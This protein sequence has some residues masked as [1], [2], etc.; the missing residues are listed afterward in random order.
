MQRIDDISWL[1][2]GLSESKKFTLLD[3]GRLDRVITEMGDPANQYPTLCV[4][5]GGRSK[6]ACLRRLYPNNNIKRHASTAEIKLRYD[7]DS[8]NTTRPV[9]FTD[10]DLKCMP[11]AYPSTN[12]R[13]KLERSISWDTSSAEKALYIIW[14]R[15]VFL[16]ADVICVFANDFGDL[17]DVAGFLLECLSLQAP[18]SLPSAVQ[19]RVIIVLEA[20]LDGEQED[21]QNVEHFYCKLHKEGPNLREYFSAVHL[22]RLESSHLSE[23][24]RYERLR[25]LIM[26][27]LDDM[28][29]VREDHRAL[30][31]ATHLGALFR[32]AFQ[33]TAE[34]ICRP[35]DFVK[36]TR[37][38]DEVPSTLSRSLAHYL[39]IGAKAGLRYEE[40]ATS[41]SSALLMDHYIPGMLGKTIEELVGVV[42]CRLV[43]QF[44]LLDRTGQSSLEFRREQ[45]RASSGRIC[46]IRSNKICLVCLFRVAQ[47][48]LDCGH[49]L[50]DLCAQLFG[51]PAPDIEYNFTIDACL[52]CLYQRPL[53]IDVLPPTMNPTVLAIDGGGVRGVIPLEFLILVQESL[54]CCPLQDLIDL[55]VGTSS[56]MCRSLSILGLFNM[57]WGVKKCADVF[58]RMARRIFH[59][60]RS[61]TLARASQAM[62]GSHSFLGTVH[63]WL[64]WL[65]YDSCYDGRVFDLA[66]KEVY[67]INNR[68]FDSLLLEA[69][70][71]RYSKTKVGVVATS[72]ARETRSFV[73]GNFN[74]TETAAED[75]GKCRASKLVELVFPSD[76]DRDWSRLTARS[77]FP[78]ADIRGIG[79][80]Q[81][82]GLRDNLAADIA[83][84]LCRQIWPS[85]K[86]PARLLSMGTGVTARGSDR[87]PHFRHVFQDGFLRRGFD[88]WMSSMDTE[89]KWLEMIG[90]LEDIYKEDYLR[91][92]IPLRDMPSAIDTVEVMEEYRNLV[93]ISPGSARMAREAATA[94]L[95]SRFYFV[96]ETLPEDT[97]TPFWC[98]GTIRCK[99]RAKQVVD[100]LGHLHPQGL[101]Y[102][103]D[104]E[105]IGPLKG[106]SELCSACGRYCRP[107]SF[108]VAHPDKVVNIYLK[109]PTKKRWRISGFPESMASFTGCQQLYAPFGRRDHGRLGSSPCSSCDG[110][111][112]PT[113]GMRR[114]R[115]SG[116]SWNSPT[117]RFRSTDADQDELKTS[118][119]VRCVGRTI[120]GALRRIRRAGEHWPTYKLSEKVTDMDHQNPQLKNLNRAS[121]RSQCRNHLAQHICKAATL[122]SQPFHSLLGTGEQLGIQLKPEEVRLKSTEELQY[123]WKIDDPLLEPVFDKHLSKHSMGL[124]IKLQQAEKDIV[125][126][127]LARAEAKEDVQAYETMIHESQMALNLHQQDIQHWIMVATYYQGNYT[128][129]ANA[130]KYLIAFAQGVE[131]EASPLL[132]E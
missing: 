121:W 11:S 24:A 113:H 75:C 46:Q 2:L 13:P 131:S 54:G 43:D 58:D 108:L 100:T 17:L 130:L 39:E 92:N 72:I 112:R 35:F 18:S 68:I 52:C 15:L 106:L 120:A 27:Q 71:T 14:A 98:Y 29:T 66:L 84:R 76:I 10:G 80:F 31:S 69:S 104:S 95:V 33:H 123:V 25:A 36:A 109:T 101:D 62:F 122:C 77:F 105:T 21:I 6:D 34:G 114:K 60:R 97:V 59:E 26:G 81:D 82:G 61:S 93:T 111:G 9:L 44:E 124:L 126:L 56:G 89:S 90:Q 1:G 41:I 65:L 3:Y 64:L 85:R 8:L 127:E 128:R 28:C 5:M 4:Y 12:G 16:F 74:G 30:F 70:S 78:P 51:T 42:E 115:S 73:F 47:H 110:R 7:I 94:L 19:P 125:A 45:L 107:V 86:H 53:V 57:Q 99:G 20:R 38:Q 79:S 103:T 83:R 88:A 50:C 40:L 22:I 119:L 37:A 117:K 96:L 32:L 55:A 63:K 118:R 91:L 102:I 116:K 129:L 132:P 87:P 48:R 67:T 49:T 23:N